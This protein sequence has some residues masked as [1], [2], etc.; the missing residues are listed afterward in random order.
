MKSINLIFTLVLALLLNSCATKIA[1]SKDKKR[2]DW[3]DNPYNKY[4]ESLYLAAIGEGD[5]RK[6]AENN[7]IGN[8]SLIFES[9]IKVE[10]TTEQRY[11]ELF[12]KEGS[13][14]SK[15]LKNKQN[16]KTGS[17]QTLFNVQYGDSYTDKNGRNYVIA[18]LD[19][20]ETGELYET[21]IAKNSSKIKF[22]LE[23]SSLS[24]DLKRSYAY[25]N[26]ATVVNSVNQ[27]LVSQL[28]II[29]P[30]F[31]NNSKLGYDPNELEEKAANS[32]KLICFAGNIENDEDGKVKNI[33]QE[34][35]SNKG[36]VIRE[37]PLLTLDGSV[38]FEDLDLPR[39]EKFVRWHLDLN[40]NDS[41]GN[42]LVSLSEDGR[43]GHLSKGEAKARAIRTIRSKVEKKFSKSL[44]NYFDSLVKK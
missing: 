37:N 24:S 32:T 15:T 2:P 27:S 6:A 16:V 44:D 11:E 14:F 17:N 9:K 4:R 21:K 19:R 10:N 29:S 23:N 34:F 1:T 5:T 42:T 38:N 40:L 7:A 33:L 39:A 12:T 22:Y 25:L 28:Q 35:L 31:W 8:I 3:L 26:A 36:F 41:A 43:E 18:Y 30:D 20:L 13:T